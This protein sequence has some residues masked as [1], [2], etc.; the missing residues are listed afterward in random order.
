MILAGINLDWMSK[1]MDEL[2][3]RPGVSAVLIDSEG[4][5]A[6]D[7]YRFDAGVFGDYEKNWFASDADAR[8]W[9]RGVAR[10][11]ALVAAFVVAGFFFRPLWLGVPLL[12]LLRAARRVWRW[13]AREPGASR[14]AALFNVPRL[15]MVTWLNFVIDAA[16]LYGTFQWFV[17]DHAGVPEE[18]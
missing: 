12:L 7:R 14:A 3:G 18:K 11:Y 10:F 4:T 1:V 16:T 2:G 17:H 9:Q 13:H 5:Q 6:I 8:E 15:L